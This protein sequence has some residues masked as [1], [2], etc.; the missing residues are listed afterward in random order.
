MSRILQT[1]VQDIQAVRWNGLNLAIDLAPE[2][3]RMAAKKGQEEG[4]IYQSFS[5][6]WVYDRDGVMIANPKDFLVYFPAFEKIVPMRQA[7]FFLMMGGAVH[8]L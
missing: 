8:E 7:Q 2:W 3:L 5:D 4:G 1:P 6:L